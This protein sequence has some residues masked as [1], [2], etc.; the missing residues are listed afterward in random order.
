MSVPRTA[1]LFGSCLQRHVFRS[2][3]TLGHPRASIT[4]EITLAGKPLNP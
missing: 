2:A 3:T 1:G 4:P